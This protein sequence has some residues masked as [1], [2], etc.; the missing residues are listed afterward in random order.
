MNLRFHH[1]LAC[2]AIAASLAFTGLPAAYGQTAAPVAPQSPAAATARPASTLRLQSLVEDTI[3]KASLPATICVYVED[4]NGQPAA[5][6]KGEH[7]VAPASN[8]KLVTTAAGL[9]L[10]GPDF[11]FETRFYRN[12]TISNGVLQGDLIVYGGGDPGIGP[13][14]LQ[15]KRDTL[16]VLR[17]WAAKLKQAGI[18]QITGN[19]I[20]DDSY[21]D[22][23]Y[24]HPKW[25]PKER[26]EWY[27]AEISALAFNDNCIDMTWSGEGLLPDQTAKVTISPKTDY[28]QFDNQVKTVAA[29]RSTER[30]YQRGATDN[31]IV[32]TGTLNVGTTNIDSAA[33]HDGALYTVTEL[34]QVLQ[35]QGI[36][37]GGKA[38]KQRGA[39]ATLPQDAGLFVHK[40]VSLLQVCQTINLVSQNFYAEC[41]FKTIG[42]VKAGEGSFNAAGRV[43]EDFCK[44]NQIYSVG[45]HAVDGSGLSDEN[46]VTPRQLV[47]VLKFMDTHGLKDKWRSTLPQGQVR[48]SLKNRFGGV[49]EARRIFGKTGSIGGVRSLS[50]FVK[51]ASG[52]DVYY[53]IVLNDLD[54]KDVPA[55]MKLI[56]KIAV[57]LA[58]SK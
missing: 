18:T 25:Y 41:V 12:G 56:D 13:R 34:K 27:E 30:Y 36:Q 2:S 5:D 53:S 9:T 32:A 45:H 31:H 40:S 29:G 8:N 20:A 26:G 14:Y 52:K 54:N 11:H 16:G 57:E 10:L 42:K 43:V 51:D 24:F 39:A 49:A 47:S 19:I 1:V 58:K 48:G 44:K 35:Q 33:I 38:I 4:V 21:F 22:D 37:V 55:G 23:V 28:I 50:G 17:Q 6:V 46:R 15:D 3:R 7:P